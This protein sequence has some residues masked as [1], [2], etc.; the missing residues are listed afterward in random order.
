MTLSS[1][2]KEIEAI[3][4]AL[5]GRYGNEKELCIYCHS[6]KYDASGIIHEEK[7]PILRLRRLI[8]KSG[9]V[10]KRK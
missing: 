4:D 2:L 10:E 5:N 6:N 3:L 7:C 9:N 1:E 8:W